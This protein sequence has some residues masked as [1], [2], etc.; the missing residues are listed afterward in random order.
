MPS[1]ASSTQPSVDAPQGTTNTKG[2]QGDEWTIVFDVL[3]SLK[4]K[5]I[6][7]EKAVQEHQKTNQ[8]LEFTVKRQ[9]DKNQRL[10]AA[11]LDLRTKCQ[12]V[13][14]QAMRAEDSLIQ[15]RKDLHEVLE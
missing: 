15:M 5:S 4:D 13:E 9:Q 7:A 8:E 2:S 3:T 11:N 14:D 10:I 6:V 1:P 12:D